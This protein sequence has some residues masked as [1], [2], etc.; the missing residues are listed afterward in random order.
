MTLKR[1]HLVLSYSC[2]TYASP[3]FRKCLGDLQPFQEILKWFLVQ[4]DCRRIGEHM[5]GA[6]E[7][8]VDVLKSIHSDYRIVTDVNGHT[9]SEMACMPFFFLFNCTLLLLEDY[10]LSLRDIL[11]DIDLSYRRD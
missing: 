1:A 5:D 7:F 4:V 3:L 9:P 6:N 2:E 8:N 11:F 10:G